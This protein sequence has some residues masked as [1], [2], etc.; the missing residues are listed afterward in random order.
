MAKV[1][2]GKLNF[3]INNETIRLHINEVEVEVKSYLSYED[4]C[5]FIEEVVNNVLSEADNKFIN[6]MKVDFY[7]VLALVKYYTNISF[8]DKQK[9]DKEKLYNLIVG[10]RFDKQ[11]VDVLEWEEYGPLQNY[12]N[13][14]LKDINH[15]DNSVYGIMDN[16]GKDYNNLNLDATT[17]RDKIADPENMTLLKEVISKLG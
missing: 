13:A 17:I 16:L 7:F 11:I 9:E 1:P 10:N 2:F 4:K 12:I 5:K 3:K 14:I 8:T 6:Y 15:Y